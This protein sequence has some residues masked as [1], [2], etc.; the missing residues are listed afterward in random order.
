MVPLQLVFGSPVLRAQV[1]A[2]E[3]GP[4]RSYAKRNADKAPQIRRRVGPS[5]TTQVHFDGAVLKGGSRNDGES[6]GIIQTLRTG[7]ANTHGAAT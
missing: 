6:A 1:E 5:V 4:V 7:I 3:M 2:L